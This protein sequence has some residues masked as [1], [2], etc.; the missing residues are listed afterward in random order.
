MVAANLR[1]KG[2]EL[3]LPTYKSKRR[4]SDRIKMLDVPLF[5]GYLF[6][7]FDAKTRLPILTTPGV[8]FIVGVGKSPEPVEETEITSIRTV[9][10]SGL[11][12]E[13]YPYVT[14]G[15]TVEVEQGSLSGLTGIVTHL[16]NQARL[17]VSVNLLMRS[18]SVEID[19]TWIRPV[20]KAA[21]RERY[22][23]TPGVVTRMEKP[24]RSQ[25]H[26]CAE[27]N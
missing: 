6:C 18:V 2:Y 9:V 1:N 23:A 8:N 27:S 19:R 25:K 20:G 13:P 16:K 7:R 17:I 22:L 3:F 26:A 14:V 24:D 10:A 15:Q 21:A 5:P 12:Y 4:W 11:L